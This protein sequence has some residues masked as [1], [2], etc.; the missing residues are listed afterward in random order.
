[1]GSARKDVCLSVLGSQLEPVRS[2]RRSWG[3]G[4]SLSVQ[5]F[6]A[7]VGPCLARRPG[8]LS[9]WKLPRSMPGP[10]QR[11]L[12]ARPPLPR[13]HLPTAA[14]WP[15]QC[16]AQVWVDEELAACY[17]W[18]GPCSMGKGAPS[19]LIP[20]PGFPGTWGAIS[21]PREPSFPT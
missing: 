2:P 5:S 20:A 8:P 10:L 21:W 11:L 4:A 12:A 16:G 14:H 17:P 7:L 13:A 3:L 18:L 9:Q 1:M 15:G 19:Q 6:P